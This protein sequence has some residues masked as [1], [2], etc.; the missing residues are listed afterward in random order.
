MGKKH[1]DTL[2]IFLLLM[3]LL[4]AVTPAFAA[5]ETSPVIRS[6]QIDA[7][8]ST[9]NTLAVTQEVTVDLPAGST[10]FQL[11][12]PTRFTLNKSVAGEETPMRYHALVS[13]VYADGT[14]FE[15]AEKN[16]VFTILLGDKS[17]MEGQKTFRIQFLYDLGDDRIGA[18]DDFF[19]SFTGT[20]LSCP[21]DRLS[22][23]LTFPKKTD[24]TDLRLYVGA[25]GGLNGGKEVSY[26]VDGQTVQATALDLQAGQALTGY[27]RLP[28][29]YY[30]DT[31]APSLLP[32]Y[33]ATAGAALMFLAGL[34][35]HRQ[36]APSSSPASPEQVQRVPMDLSSAE[37]GRLRGRRPLKRPA[38]SL[39][40]WLGARGCLKLTLEQG[41]LKVEKTG[42]ADP[43]MTP[44]AKAFYDTLFPAGCTE[45][46]LSAPGDLTGPIQA[47]DE[48][49]SRFFTGDRR[50]YKKGSAAL[51]LFL[52]LAAPVPS[53]LVLGF[54]GLGLAL[55]SWLWAAGY[56]LL[57]LTGGVL[58]HRLVRGRGALPFQKRLLLGA[59]AVLCGIAALLC[60]LFSAL[61]GLVPRTFLFA[62]ALVGVAAEALAAFYL[63]ASDYAAQQSAR[64]Q[65]LQ[66]FLEKAE[67][68]RLRLLLEEETDYYWQMLPYAYALGS[69]ER[70]ARRFDL[71]QVSPP[72]WLSA[73][74]GQ[75]AL[76]PLRAAVALEKLLPQLAQP[77]PDAPSGGEEGRAPAPLSET[78]QTQEADHDL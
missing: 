19:Y 16:G 72:D 62:A 25:F 26:T 2:G 36:K 3:A 46:S 43:A 55:E 70:W 29:G 41:G 12:V 35:L 17:P 34:F 4:I 8:L 66:S 5:K 59:G 1:A 39:L 77:G 68:P 22:L 37:A 63:P 48:Q 6:W 9:Q 56:G 58:L 10:S 71:L 32:L 44:A 49:L 45:V 78:A 51:A 64:F 14:P 20:A 11:S 28:R 7:A 42:E 60:P 15:T 18:Y 73:G 69:A 75:E 27:L 23:R 67:L 61:L 65:A 31:R 21:V 38:L 54:A 74:D 13:G 40:L 50:L 24:L 76:T 57:V 30:T 52:T 47:A 33:L 53:A